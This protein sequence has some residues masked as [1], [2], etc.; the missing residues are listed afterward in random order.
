MHVPFNSGSKIETQVHKYQ[1]IDGIFQ[2]PQGLQ[3]FGLIFEFLGIQTCNI[4]DALLLS[5]GQGLIENH[6][7]KQTSEAFLRIL[8]GQ[9]QIFLDRT[10]DEVE[11]PQ[12]R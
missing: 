7:G 2:F 11:L 8:T 12:K 3:S 1:L 10:D 5:D 6:L 4:G 9:R